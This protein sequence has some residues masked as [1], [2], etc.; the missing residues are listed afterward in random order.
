MEHETESSFP[1]SDVAIDGNEN[2]SLLRFGFHEPTWTMQFIN[3][4]IFVP[5]ASDVRWFSVFN[6]QC[7]QNIALV[8]GSHSLCDDK[9][10]S[11]KPGA[12]NRILDRDNHSTPVSLD[13]TCFAFVCPS[14]HLSCCLFHILTEL[15]LV[16][17][18][19][20]HI[21]AQCYEM[22]SLGT[23]ITFRFATSWLEPER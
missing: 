20:G 1:F 11:Q 23:C 5:C 4:R 9:V 10:G 6:H 21:L 3:F 17:Q 19:L 7:M 18:R 14:F 16:R 13:W 8:C 2:G 12:I 22:I 15:E